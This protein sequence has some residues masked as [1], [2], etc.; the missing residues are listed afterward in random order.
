MREVPSSSEVHHDL[1]QYILFKRNIGSIPLFPVVSGPTQQYISLYWS[2]DDI[3]F[4]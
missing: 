2:E 1:F 4:F 3:L